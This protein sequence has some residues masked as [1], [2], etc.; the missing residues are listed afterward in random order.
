MTPHAT[1]SSV[2]LVEVGSCTYLE[3]IQIP[4][5]D[6]S[7]EHP[8]VGP[9]KL[10]ERVSWVWLVGTNSLR[11]AENEN[12]GPDDAISNKICPNPGCCGDW[13]NLEAIDR[14]AGTV[15]GGRR[16]RGGAPTVKLRQ[17]LSQLLEGAL[18][19]SVVRSSRMEAM[20]P[21]S[22]PPLEIAPRPGFL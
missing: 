12:G 21:A 17:A 11:R 20:G 9:E 3:G 18:L 6:A 19:P 10:R 2:L 5:P 13:I 7:Q 14:W 16:P 8:S 22:S 4:I 15:R 1:T